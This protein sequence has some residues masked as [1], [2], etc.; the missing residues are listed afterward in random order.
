MKI[1]VIRDNHIK[2]WKLIQNMTAKNILS[3]CSKMTR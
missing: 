1:T 2:S 3:P